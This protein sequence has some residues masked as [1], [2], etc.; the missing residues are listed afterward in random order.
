MTPA[1]LIL[2]RLQGVREVGPQRWAARCPAHEDRSP[3]LSIR[4]T[5]D[6]KLLLHCFTGCAPDEILTA[7]GLT[8][9]DLYPTDRWRE[10]EARTLAHGHKRLQKM[11]SEIS[12]ADYAR[13]VLTIAAADKRE[14]KSHDLWDRATI[15]LAVN[16]MEEERAHG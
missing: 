8:W 13:H 14:G 11:L 15:A 6:G 10:A 1:D 7:L 9:R 16:I 3:S 12:Q 2:T 4:A 5:D